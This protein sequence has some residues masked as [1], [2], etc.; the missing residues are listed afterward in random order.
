MAEQAGLNRRLPPLQGGRNFRDLGGYPTVDGQQVRWNRIYRSG[1]LTDLTEADRSQLAALGI[2]T[3]C[4]LRSPSE[5]KR[6]PTQWDGDNVE[7]LQSEREF[8]GVSLRELLR[9]SDELSAA[10]MREA[11]LRLYRRIPALFAIPYAALFRTLAEGRV[12]LI[13]HCAAGKDRTGVAAALI[14]MGLGVPRKVAM[15]DYTL[16]NSV[17]DLEVVLFERRLRGIGITDEVTRLHGASREVRAPLLAAHPDYL[18][19]A[20]E[21][22]ERDHGSVAGYLAGPLGVTNAMLHQIRRHLLE[23]PQK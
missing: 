20:L 10:A 23:D 4:D 15:E 12:P 11:M 5:R 16:T 8:A 14:L 7:S 1:A 9:E 22:L 17:I 19:A 13:L 3:I 2:R 18:G 6:E 21:Q